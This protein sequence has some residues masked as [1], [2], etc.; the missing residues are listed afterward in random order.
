[1]SP[2]IARRSPGPWPAVFLMYAALPPLDL[3]PLAWIAPV[4][5]LMLARRGELTGRRP[6]RAIWLAGF[7]FWLGVLHWLRLPH[8]ATSIGWVALSFYLAFYIPLFVGLVRVAV[9]R[10]RVPLIVAAPVVWVGL[11]L[12]KGHFLGG[13]TMGS[14]EH[15]QTHW[16]DI[17]QS[18]DMIGGYG[19]SGIIMLVAACVARMLPFGGRRAAIWPIA[20]A[21]R[22]DGGRAGLRTFS[23]G[24]NAGQARPPASR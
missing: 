11:E 6:Y 15:T 18:A 5:W 2:G 23:P 19:V 16:L 17:I 21:G 12:A 1:M 4:P 13:F 9:H 8:W 22:D 14:L 20:A 10:L 7:V 3:W 24:R